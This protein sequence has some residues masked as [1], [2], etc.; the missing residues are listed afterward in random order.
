MMMHTN[1]RTTLS[2]RLPFP[3]LFTLTVIRQRE[4]GEEKERMR[5]KEREKEGRRAQIRIHSV[6]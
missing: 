6:S 4:K 1:T 3:L 2:S 5:G